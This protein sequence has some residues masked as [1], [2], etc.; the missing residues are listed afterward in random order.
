MAACAI[1]L[2]GRWCRILSRLGLSSHNDGCNGGCSRGDRNTSVKETSRINRNV[3]S[4]SSSRK[5]HSTSNNSHSSYRNHHHSSS[6]YLLALRIVSSSKWVTS[7]PSKL[8]T[9]SS[10]AMPRRQRTR[11]VLLPPS[12]LSR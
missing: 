5:N 4:S 1:A 12:L 11:L 3:R 8:H 2:S 10:I 6:R 7:L 9:S